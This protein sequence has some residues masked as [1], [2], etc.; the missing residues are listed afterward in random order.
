[1]TYIVA[2]LIRNPAVSLVVGLVIMFAVM[3]IFKIAGKSSLPVNTEV[4][5][6]E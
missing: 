6:T 2:G 5:K 1:M 4:E 3:T